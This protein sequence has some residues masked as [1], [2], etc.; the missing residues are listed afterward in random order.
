MNTA[1]QRQTLGLYVHFPWCIRKCPYCDFNSHAVTGELPE[2]AYVAQLLR[3]L[4]DDL[5]L[6]DSPPPLTSMFLGGG[7]PSLFTAKSMDT[8]LTGIQQRLPFDPA[9]EITLEA[10]PGTTDYEKFSGYVDVGINRLSIGVQSFNNQQ[11]TALGRIHSADEAQRAFAIARQAGFTNINIDLMHGLPGQSVAAAM[12]DLRQAIELGPEHISWY[13]LTIEPNTSFYNKPPVL[14]DDD[15]L[16]EIYSTGLTRLAAAGYSRYEVS[17][18]SQ[19]GR[20]GAHNLNYWQFGDYLGIGAGAHGKLSTQN[21]RQRTTKTRVPKDYLNAPNRRL[22]PIKADSL[23]LEFLMNGL[24]LNEG[25]S[26]HTYEQRTGLPRASLDRLIAKGEPKG[27]LISSTEGLRATDMGIQ[28]LN[29]VLLL[30]D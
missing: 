11:L 13:Q 27:L 4:D 10:N 17:A 2:D 8:L 30:V 24:R 12:S 21:L 14:P 19:P 22:L 23:Q 3:D 20:P 1:N 29:D 5:A 25:F 18:F 28:F 16:W 9:I 15:Q 6:L 26:W 7:T